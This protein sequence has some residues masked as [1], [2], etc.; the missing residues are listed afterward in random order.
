MR[1][2]SEGTVDMILWFVERGRAD[3]VS[4]ENAVSTVTLRQYA[5]PGLPSLPY[6]QLL[7]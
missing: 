2:G 7:H 4:P 6:R 1:G 5:R 3:H